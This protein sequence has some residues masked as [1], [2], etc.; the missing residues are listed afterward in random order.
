MK[1]NSA[2]V[3]ESNPSLYVDYVYMNNRKPP[4]D[5]V[6][7][8]QAISYAVDYKGLVDGVM[9]GQAVQMRG[10][11][12]QGLWGHDPDAFQYSYDLEKAKALLAEAGVK[13]LT[14]TYTFSQADPVWEP[15]GIALQAGL[16]Q[17]GVKLELQNLA[18]TA[19]RE[20]A[21]QGK[22]DLAAGAWTPDYA[23]P[24]MFMNY[25][26]DPSR[27]G[28]PGNRAFYSNEKV[29]ALVRQAAEIT[30][31]AQREKLYLEAQKLAIAD[32]PYLLLL[33]KNDIFVRRAAVQG[34]VYNPMLLQ[35][36]NLAEMSK[37][38]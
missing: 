6:R 21:A 22:Y 2:L 35:V 7:V 34:Y 33:Q 9:H 18:D 25:W 1:G 32:A 13:N 3:V 23:D 20:L 31:Q 17:I 28:G 10:P 37:S 14:L 12:P 26:F 27:M 5:D 8:R 15:V 11:V 29:A 38:E 24:Y 16:A 36:Y 30:D 19:K 4:L